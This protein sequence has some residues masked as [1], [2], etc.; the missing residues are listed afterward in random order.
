MNNSFVD[1]SYDLHEGSKSNYQ[2]KDINLFFSEKTADRWRSERAY[3]FLAPILNNNNQSNW[4]TIGDGR[5]GFD[6]Y[7]L[8]K[9]NKNISVTSSNIFE[10]TLELSF[11]KG[12]ITKFR[13]ENAESLT[14]T[15]A[16]YDYVFCKEA[17]HHFPR[18]YKA[19]YEML[20]VAKKA[21]ILIEPL[22]VYSDQNF[23]DHI[24]V[25]LRALFKKIRG[26]QYGFDVY[27]E[28]GNY[29]FGLSLREM[30]K[31]ALA[32]NLPAIA[33][34]KFNDCFIKSNDFGS[35]QKK[36]NRVKLG[37]FI[38]NMLSQLGVFKHILS[39]V[40]IFKEEPSQ[41]EIMGLDSL[42]YKVEMLPRNPYASTT[43]R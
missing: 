39:T 4:L 2:K 6:A 1:I 26:H 23:M 17:F 9:I 36:L 35:E 33:C 24:F 27:E 40:I 18:P 42:G 3:N 12:F 8:K 20:R 15:D 34:F 13:K 10:D 22:D 28:E 11:K 38:K 7:S 30:K 16:S 5:Y 25:G 19:L 31:I 29:A 21:A 43:Y 41:S 14:C 32:M 37:I